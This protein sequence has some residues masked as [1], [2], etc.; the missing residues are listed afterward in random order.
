MNFPI[1]T[2]GYLTSH[3]LPKYKKVLGSRKGLNTARTAPEIVSC[4]SLN[5]K[6]NTVLY[7]QQV[8]HIAIKRPKV[9]FLFF[10]FCSYEIDDT[11]STPFKPGTRKRPPPPIFTVE[12]L[13][14]RERVCIIL[15]VFCLANVSACVIIQA[16]WNCYFIGMTI[17]HR[18]SKSSHRHKLQPIL[19]LGLCFCFATGCIAFLNHHWA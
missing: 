11:Q 8:D 17:C 19:K 14:E 9:V 15:L 7:L 2:L 4:A 6:C 10:F 5:R 13:K 1:C 3:R 18:L 12:H 16:K